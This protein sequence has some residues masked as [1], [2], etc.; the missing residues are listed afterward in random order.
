MNTS[1][2]INWPKMI[3]QSI[4]YSSIQAAI[5]SVEMSS[6]FSCANFCKDQ[7]TLQNAADS[8]RNYMYVAILWMIATMLVMYGQYGNPGLIAGLVT[9]LAYIAW[10][11]FSY[12]HTFKVAAQKYGLQEPKVF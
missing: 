1:K 11:Y 10:V 3:G 9:N 4:F 12:V 7:I 2:D 8:L 6:K 5:A